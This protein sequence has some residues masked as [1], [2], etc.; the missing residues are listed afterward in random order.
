M[1]SPFQKSLLCWPL[2]R[3]IGSLRLEKTSKI[4][5]SNSPPT[6]MFIKA[7]I[8]RNESTLDA[9]TGHTVPSLRVCTESN[10]FYSQRVHQVSSTIWENPSGKQ[11]IYHVVD[12]RWCK[13]NNLW[14][15]HSCSGGKKDKWLTKLCVDLPP[16]SETWAGAIC[17]LSFPV[18]KALAHNDMTLHRLFFSDP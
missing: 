17:P 1:N 6:T 12:L 3:I 2:F 5:Q 15:N 7:F 8:H 14:E 18:S 11:L 4:I 16:Y 9:P 13:G 10:E